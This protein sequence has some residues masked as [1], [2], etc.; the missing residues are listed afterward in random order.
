MFAR[1]LVCSVIWLGEG[2]IELNSP[3]KVLLSQDDRRLIALCPC[4]D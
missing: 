3:E 4:E 2:K 1:L